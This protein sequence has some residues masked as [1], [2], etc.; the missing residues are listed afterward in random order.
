MPISGVLSSSFIV[1]QQLTELLR[2]AEHCDRIPRMQRTFIGG[3]H[4]RLMVVAEEDDVE[5]VVIFHVADGFV[6]KG[7]LF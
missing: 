1:M 3:V 4:F 5:M 2:H 6:G 7:C